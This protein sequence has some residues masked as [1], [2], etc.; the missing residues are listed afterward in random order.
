MVRHSWRVCVMLC[1]DA[2]GQFV[3]V[4]ASV[5]ANT[6]LYQRLRLTSQTAAPANNDHRCKTFCIICT[7]AHIQPL[8]NWQV[9]DGMSDALS[10]KLP[11]NTTDDIVWNVNDSFR[12]IH[13]NT[14]IIH[15]PANGCAYATVLYL[16]SSV[17]DIMYC[18][19]QCIIEQK[20]LLT[21]YKKSYMRN[22][23]IPEWMTLT[24]L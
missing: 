11:I 15:D 19:K 18:A 4:G 1:I 5:A 10:T 24:F 14:A 16:S 7:H 13:V 2:A 12:L 20:L 21:A 9:W 8:V 17:C 6:Q 23:L 22:R 3:S